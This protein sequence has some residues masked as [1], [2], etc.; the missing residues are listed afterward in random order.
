[1]MMRKIV[2]AFFAALMICVLFVSCENTIESNPKGTKAISFTLANVGTTRSASLSTGDGD[3]TVA[4]SQLSGHKIKLTCADGSGYCSLSGAKDGFVAWPTASVQLG[5]GTWTVYAQGYKT[6]NETDVVYYQNTTG[7]T[8]I[9][10]PKGVSTDSGMTWGSSVSIAESYCNTAP[11][12]IKANSSLTVKNESETTITIGSGNYSGYQL[13]W[14]KTTTAEPINLTTAGTISELTSAGTD[15]TEW[16]VPTTAIDVGSNTYVLV[17]IVAS[18][19]PST[20]FGSVAVKLENLT[21]GMTYTIGSGNADFVQF[22]KYGVDFEEPSG[23]MNYS[24]GSIGP[25][26]GFIFYDCDADNDS[27]NDGAGPDGLKSTVCGWQ[28]LEAAPENVF[29]DDP[30]DLGKGLRI[31]NYSTNDSVGIVF[32][33]VFDSNKK[34]LYVNNSLTYDESDCTKTSIGSG[35]TNT[36]LIVNFFG[37]TVRWDYSDESLA[38]HYAAKE[39]KNYSYGGCDD[40]FLP[41]KDELSL[42]Y[43]NLKVNDLGNFDTED[44]ALYWSSSESTTYSDASAWFISFD[45]GNAN[46][47][48]VVARYNVRAIRAFSLECPF[49]HDYTSE[50]IQEQSCTDSEIVQYTCSDCGHSYNYVSKKPTGHS[51]SSDWTSDDSTHWHAATCGHDVTSDNAAHKFTSE[52]VVTYPTQTTDGL[53]EKTCSICGRV[54]QEAIPAGTYLVG[55]RGPAGGYIFYDCDAD[56]NSTNGG[57]GPDGLNSTICGWRYLE[58]APTIMYISNPDSASYNSPQI[59][60]NVTNYNEFSYGDWTPYGTEGISGLS[61]S[62][63]RGRANT[64]IIISS[65]NTKTL[66]GYVYESN[67]SLSLKTDIGSSYAANLCGRIQNNYNNTVYSDW[68]LPS[69]DELAAIKQNIFGK[70]ETP[71]PFGTYLSSSQYY[72]YDDGERYYGCKSYDIS[73]YSSYPDEGLRYDSYYVIPVRQFI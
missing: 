16:A 50:I 55:M 11:A 18:T 52:T 10:G 35:K 61:N 3:N 29:V 32:G 12:R 30:S 65:L 54:V 25:A 31:L 68:F 60:G 51:Y 40:W 66:C 8:F 15:F 36:D 67:G 37:D 69:F 57:A 23:P 64:S 4:F 6:E 34:S 13:K 45:S 2:S 38:T 1:M 24:V 26:G 33:T 22:G 73:S 72:E 43:S 63:G 27:T 59:G 14:Y 48:T 17:A 28:Y 7:A 5:Y 71:Y 42:M 53:V 46:D 19:N 70:E 9:G 62:I 44:C 39:C 56:N 58:A 41:S 49:G 21:E 47:I 20:I